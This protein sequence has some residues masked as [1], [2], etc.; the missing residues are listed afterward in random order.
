M[1]VLLYYL[2][3]LSPLLLLLAVGF[4]AYGVWYTKGIRAR[5]QR[6]M[7]EKDR[8]LDELLRYHDE[9]EERLKYYR[10]GR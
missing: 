6:E 7:E 3:F 4:V 9:A 5:H 8:K 2:M 10:P 1:S